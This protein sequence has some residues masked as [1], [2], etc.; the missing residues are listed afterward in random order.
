MS[1][2]FGIPQFLLPSDSYRM[3]TGKEVPIRQSSRVIDCGFDESVRIP[4]VQEQDGYVDYRT[5][6]DDTVNEILVRECLL[7]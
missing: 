5:I 3:F 7:I 6:Q 2:M 4:V 1:F